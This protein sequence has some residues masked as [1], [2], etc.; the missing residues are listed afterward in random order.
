MNFEHEQGN[1]KES[2]VM[3]DPL[4]RGADPPLEVETVVEQ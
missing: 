4:G 1:K 3:S 2:F